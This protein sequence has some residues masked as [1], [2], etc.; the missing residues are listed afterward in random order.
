MLNLGEIIFAPLKVVDIHRY[1]L[2]LELKELKKCDIII[3]R[4]GRPIFLCVNIY[5]Y[6]QN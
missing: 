2:F 5:R 1:Y 4:L 3:I 6:L